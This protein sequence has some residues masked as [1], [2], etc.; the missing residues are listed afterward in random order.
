MGKDPTDDVV[1]YDADIHCWRIIESLI[2]C[3]E[4]VENSLQT[5]KYS[6][7]QIVDLMTAEGLFVFWKKE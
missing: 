2:L 4:A 6:E 5:K 3:A 7:I 1:S